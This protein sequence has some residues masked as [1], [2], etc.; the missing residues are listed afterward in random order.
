[1]VFSNGTMDIFGD[2]NNV[3]A[4]AHH[5]SNRRLRRRHGEFLRR[6]HQQRPDSSDAAGGLQSAAV[7]FGAL[8]GNGVSGTG[9]V[10]IEGDARP[11]FSPGTMAFG[12]DVSFSP[13]ATLDIEI[14]GATPGT[15]HDRV[16]VADSATLAGTLAVNLMDGFVPT[17][18]QQFT[19][20]TYGSRTG[21]L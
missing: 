9:H 4:H 10:F 11:G 5:R 14:G 20:M 7:F 16:T 1:M 8:S 15:Q 12:G 21:A 2:I 18:G 17:P 6:H 19:I 13:A 3:A